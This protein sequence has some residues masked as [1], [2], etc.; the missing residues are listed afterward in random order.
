MKR[1]ALLCVAS[2]V[3]AWGTVGCAPKTPDAA[4]GGKA[5]NSPATGDAASEAVPTEACPFVLWRDDP[6]PVSYPD[7]AMIKYRKLSGSKIGKV[8]VSGGVY[9]KD[10]GSG[11]DTQLVAILVEA[12]VPGDT[13]EI[14]LAAQ[15]A[16]LS[17]Q[18][19]SGDTVV[20]IE[21]KDTQS[22]TTLSNVLSVPGR[23]G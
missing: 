8:T 23:V 6:E 11:E 1:I 20:R 21:L 16:V 7:H 12:D 5:A 22:G 13:G 17:F 4:N 19:T 3:L 18:V 2:L 15:L 9:A 14:S 10:S